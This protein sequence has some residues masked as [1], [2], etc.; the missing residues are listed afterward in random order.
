MVKLVALYRQPADP[1]AFERA[2]YV[3]HIPP[4]KKLPHLS[5]ACGLVTFVFAEEIKE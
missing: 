1:A 2:Y 4:V 3:T 5:S